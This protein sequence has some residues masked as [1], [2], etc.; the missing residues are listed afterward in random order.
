MIV[1]EPPLLGDEHA[2]GRPPPI[3]ILVIRAS[4]LAEPFERYV[5]R[6]LVTDDG[7]GRLAAALAVAVLAGGPVVSDEHE[8][9]I[10][11]GTE[12]G[13]CAHDGVAALLV[14][15]RHDVATRYDKLVA[16]EQLVGPVDPK[17][18][19]E[20]SVAVGVYLY[21][22]GVYGAHG[23]VLDG[24]LD[25]LK[26]AVAEQQPR[27]VVAA[28][29]AGEIHARQVAVCP[30][31]MADDAERV[32]HVHVAALPGAAARTSRRHRHRRRQLQRHDR[33]LLPARPPI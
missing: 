30:A 1:V 27:W 5:A 11:V 23:G 3:V 4:V 10:G 12:G 9:A 16:E 22:A 21:V 29:L 25:D 32:W 18:S 14:Q 7:D 2:G 24:D 28:C 6:C 15:R 33:A 19:A 31:R 8:D 26:G 17:S 13:T 20:G